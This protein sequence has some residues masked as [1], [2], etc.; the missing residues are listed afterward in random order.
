MTNALGLAVG[1]WFIVVS[2]H[3]T[4]L[5]DY[6]CFFAFLKTRVFFSGGGKIMY[7]FV[8]Y[9]TGLFCLPVPATAYDQTHVPSGTLVFQ[10]PTLYYLLINLPLT[11]SADMVSRNI[12]QHSCETFSTNG[13]NTEHSRGASCPIRSLNIT[14]PAKGSKCQKEKTTHT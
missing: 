4:S 5:P 8:S 11:P 10:V 14:S 1:N 9:R 7:K 3:P 6:D 12:P 2:S 13:M